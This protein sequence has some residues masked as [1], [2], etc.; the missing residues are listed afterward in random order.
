MD[1]EESVLKL[2]S[3][4]LKKMGHEVILTDDGAEAVKL[5]KESFESGNPID[6]TIMDLTIPGGMGG[7]D[8]VK[9]IL[10]IN[11][12]AKVLVASGYSTDP[13]MASHT[14]FGF[15]GALVKPFQMN[16][17]RNILKKI[18]H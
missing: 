1:D 12:E 11:A 15:S 3:R 7:K 8:A 10:N 18:L 2:I 16:D 6:L 5:Y 9:E 17:L 4:M 14:Q 13:V